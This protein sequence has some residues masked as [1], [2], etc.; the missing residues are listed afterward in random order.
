MLFYFNRKKMKHSKILSFEALIR[1][2]NELKSAGKKIVY[3]QGFFDL[4]HIG[5]VYHL[6]QSKKLGDI[7][8]VGV[9]ADRFMRKGPGRPIFKEKERLKQVAV[10]DCVD[11]LV[12]VKTP[13]A[14]E[15]ITKIKPNIYVKGADAKE[16]ADHP[17][18]PAEILYRD[19][20]FLEINASK[21]VGGKIHFTK[22]LPIHSTELLA[23][24]SDAE[25]KKISDFYKNNEFLKTPIIP[26]LEKIWLNI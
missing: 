5:H 7:L 24:L 13:T 10:L 4:L 17:R 22:S 15:P 6:E 9:V 14:I 2:V 25:L 8:I 1:S 11:F 23:K 16:K 21:S 19:N 12:L 18:D 20:L 26:F 3:A